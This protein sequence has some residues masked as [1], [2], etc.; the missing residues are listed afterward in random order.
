MYIF[1]Y[2]RL[3]LSTILQLESLIKD[4]DPNVSLVNVINNLKSNNELTFDIED[5]PI[6]DKILNW[7][8]TVTVPQWK[9]CFKNT[10]FC[11]NIWNKSPTKNRSYSQQQTYARQD[12]KLSEKMKRLKDI[13]TSN[14]LSSSF[15]SIVE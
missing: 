13:L 8:E 5:G 9:L 11:K 7:Y 6:F 1:D 2:F 12:M 3:L 15:L 14:D 4:F 10:Y